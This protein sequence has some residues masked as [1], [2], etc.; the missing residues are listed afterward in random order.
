MHLNVIVS[1]TFTVS[2]GL[3]SPFPSTGSGPWPTEKENRQRA[4]RAKLKLITT[5]ARPPM[6]R[7]LKITTKTAPLIRTGR[8]YQS[9]SM[10]DKKRLVWEFALW[11]SGLRILTAVAQVIAEVQV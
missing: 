2:K 5:K 3:N 7:N 9:I 1:F 4:E 6:L 8:R 10:Q 11:C